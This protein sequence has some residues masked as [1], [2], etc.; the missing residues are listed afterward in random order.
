M[1]RLCGYCG[2]AVDSIVSVLTHSH[3]VGGATSTEEAKENETK[4][5]S[6]HS[7]FL[8]RRGRTADQVAQVSL[9]RASASNWGLG[10]C[11]N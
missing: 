10:L 4:D 5:C 8:P 3:K 6:F 1:P 7:I 9:Q 2:G 11:M